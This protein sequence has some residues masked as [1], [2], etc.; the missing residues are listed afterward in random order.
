[1]MYDSEENLIYHLII[2]KIRSIFQRSSFSPDAISK[3][4]LY[5]GFHTLFSFQSVT[6]A[7]IHLYDHN[8]V[9]FYEL[10]CILDTYMI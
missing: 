8:F 4:Q 10:R 5:L 9:I 7:Y 3:S 2:D 1:M 6:Q